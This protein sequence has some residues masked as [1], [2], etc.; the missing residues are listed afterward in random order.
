MNLLLAL[1]FITLIRFG[2][3]SGLLLSAALYG[4]MINIVLAA[5]NMLPIELFGL[6]LDGAKVLR[7]NSLVWAIIGLPLIFAWLL[8]MYNPGLLMSILLG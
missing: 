5:F 1:F 6:N 2:L 4:V 8:L 7:A 3:V